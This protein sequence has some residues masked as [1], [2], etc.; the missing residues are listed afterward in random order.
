MKKKMRHWEWA[1]SFWIGAGL[2]SIIN[3]W[4]IT[5]NK[6]A[7]RYSWIMFFV[8]I[9]FIVICTIYMLVKNKKSRNRQNDKF[10]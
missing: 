1:L 9:I 2:M 6:Q 10:N 8:S 5:Q 4:K 3:V 7:L